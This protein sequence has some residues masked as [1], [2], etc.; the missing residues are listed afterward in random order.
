MNLE[1][2][3]RHLIA[4]DAAARRL[5]GQI[6]RGKG[7]F[8]DAVRCLFREADLLGGLMRRNIL[9]VPEGDRA[10]LLDTLLRQRHAET[11]ALLGEVQAQ[12]D[13]QNGL[14]LAAQKA[15]Y[16]AERVAKAGSA[17]EDKTVPDEVIQRRAE[18]VAS[19]IAKSM[20]DDFFRKNAEF[21]SSAGLKCWIVRDAVT[22]CCPWCTDMAGR[23]AY[24]D[25]PGD[26]YGRHDNCSC[27]VTYESGRQRQDVWSKRTWEAPAADAGADAPTVFTAEQA[28]EKQKQN[29]PTYLTGGIRHGILNPEEQKFLEHILADPDMSPAYRQI[30]MDRFSQGS[31]LSQKAVLANKTL[32]QKLDP[33]D[34]I[35]MDNIMAQYQKYI[36]RYPDSSFDYFMIDYKLKAAGIRNAGVPLPAKPK[37]VL[38]I[39][40][41]SQR[42]S[43]PNHIFQRMSERGVSEAD[44]KSII[45]D[46]KVMFVQWNGQRQ[47]FRT[48]K[49]AVTIHNANGQ[50]IYKTTWSSADFNSEEKFI[51]E[52][53]RRYVGL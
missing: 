11:F 32:L 42:C 22:G 15:E 7:S 38:L 17:L 37:A 4:E 18:A 51:L 20:S 13:A 44:M 19:N 43:D 28:A 12:M 34:I 29:Q 2:A 50:W 24:G 30:L 49:G 5:R 25:E 14:H 41:P 10:A 40:D 31:E 21:R 27:T 16:P 9:S 26:V 6:E 47:T 52:V 3:L 46:A 39:P 33:S 1:E 45:Q 23:Y 35:N 53:I 36:H 48:A 8:A